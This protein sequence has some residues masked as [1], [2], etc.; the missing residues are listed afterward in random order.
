VP[1]DERQFRTFRGYT[2]ADEEQSLTPSLEDYLEMLF[3][4]GSDKSYVRLGELATALHVR[5][6]SVTKAVQRL[7]ETGYVRYERYGILELTPLG[8]DTG[9]YLLHRHGLI[10]GF[11]RLLGVTENA[12]K[13]TER[14]EH[15][16]SD[17]LVSQMVKFT[18]YAKD[19]P[20]W[21]QGYLRSP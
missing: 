9:S 10:E 13:D 11:L 8:K 7:A 3:R 6:P 15:I 17:E 2:L 18:E 16:I 20:V 5:P 1:D 12:L 4:L 21:L 14:I 19:N